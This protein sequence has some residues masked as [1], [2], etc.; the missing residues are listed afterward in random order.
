MS[1]SERRRLLGLLGFLTFNAVYVGIVMAPVLTQIAS[2]FRITTGTAGLVVAAYGAPGI[3]V[4]VV[5][6]PYSDRFGRKR[7]LVTGSLIM[8]VFT[9]LSAFATSFAVLVAMRIIAGVGG[10]VIFPNVTATVGDNFPYRD[11]GSAMGTVIG[12]NTMAGVI[13]VPLAGILAEATSWRVSVGLVGVLSIVAALLLLWKLHPAQTP[14]SES[15]IREM[16]RS[17]VT[18]RSALGAIGS[19]FLGALYWFTWATYIVVFFENA[20]GLSQGV[21]SILALTQGLGVLVG[22]QLG[23]RLGARIG[24]KPIVAGSV[25]I[26][27]VLLLLQTN[28]ALPLPATAVLNLLLSAVIGA[29]FASNTT[30]LTEQ[31]PEARGTLLALSASVTSASIV[32]GAAIGGLLIDGAGFW[33]LGAFCFVAAVLAALVVWTF[34]RE[35]PIDLEIAPAV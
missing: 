18:N 2:E 22:S 13:G 8:G 3:V 20:F 25:F 31:V 33:A 14:L 4:A 28:L 15:G 9:L 27:G 24:H 21:A 5:T 32:V 30:L 1:P 26:S 19:S 34:V 6:G 35:E 16:Y 7:F 17:I 12:L 23:G 10:S 11:R 29:R